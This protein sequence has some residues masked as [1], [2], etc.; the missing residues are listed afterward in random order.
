MK[1]D[2]LNLSRNQDLKD[3]RER[4]LYRCLE[5]LP[6]FISW[7]TIILA[8]LLSWLLPL[9]AAIFIIVFDFF[10]LFRISYLSC[11]QLVNG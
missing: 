10:W 7:M 9:A 2:Y 6:G 4:F 3:P 1:K 8:L 11:H 5:I